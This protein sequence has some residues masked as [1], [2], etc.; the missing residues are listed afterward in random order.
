MKMMMLWRARQMQAGADWDSMIGITVGFLLLAGV[1]FL[2]FLVISRV[3]KQRRF[4]SVARGRR[5]QR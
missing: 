1:V 2:L 3:A 4:R 5:R